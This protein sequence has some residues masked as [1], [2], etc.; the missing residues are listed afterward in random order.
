MSSNICWFAQ[1]FTVVKFFEDNVPVVQSA[2]LWKRTLPGILLAVK[3]T[4]Q[5]NPLMCKGQE[6]IPLVAIDA[7]QPELRSYYIARGHSYLREK[8][9]ENSWIHESTISLRFLN[10]ILTFLRLQVST[11][12]SAFQRMLFMNI[13]QSWVFFIGVDRFSFSCIIWKRCRKLWRRC[14]H[15][16]G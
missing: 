14:A 8:G 9:G 13:E 2:P 16:T 7:G 5:E 6:L 12:G 11:F 10:I 4:L 1:H 3:L 15:K